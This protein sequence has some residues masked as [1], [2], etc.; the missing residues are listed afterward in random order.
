MFKK[1]KKKYIVVIKHNLN[2]GFCIIKTK[3]DSKLYTSPW[4]RIISLNN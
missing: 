4:K 1:I 3:I 2:R